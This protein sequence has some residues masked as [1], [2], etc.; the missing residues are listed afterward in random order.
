MAVTWNINFAD[1]ELEK[2]RDDCQRYL[3]WSFYRGV[4][5]GFQRDL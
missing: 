4:E 3:D 5:E 2:S 1:V